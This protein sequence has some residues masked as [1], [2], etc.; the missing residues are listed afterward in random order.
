MC[1]KTAAYTKEEYETDRLISV[2]LGLLL[3]QFEMFRSLYA[4]LLFCLALL[5]LKT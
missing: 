2:A 4:E 1:E 3:S 5:A